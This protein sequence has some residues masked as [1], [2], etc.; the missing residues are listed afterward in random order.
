MDTLEF[1]HIAKHTVPA[2]YELCLLLAA[3][4]SSVG[5]PRVGLGILLQYR[6]G[7]RPGELCKLTPNDVA[8]APER[9]KTRYHHLS[10][11]GEGWNEERK[12][13]IRIVT[14]I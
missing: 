7:L 11:G 4:L 1:H 3:V 2:G 12:G 14:V 6:L 5:R 13:T 9:N 10:M 8:A